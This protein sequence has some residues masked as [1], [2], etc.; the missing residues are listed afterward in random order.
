M[1]RNDWRGPS[2]SSTTR[3]VP[4]RRGPVRVAEGGATLKGADGILSITVVDHQQ[5]PAVGVMSHVRNFTPSRP[6]DKQIV[7]KACAFPVAF[8]SWAA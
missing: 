2:S 1:T 7:A 8:K 5:N 3:S 6:L 4:R